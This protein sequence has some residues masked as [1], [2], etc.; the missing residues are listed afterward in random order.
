MQHPVRHHRST[1]E[2]TTEAASLIWKI[3]LSRSLG[4]IKLP[5]LVPSSVIHRRPRPLGKQYLTHQPVL[6]QPTNPN[7]EEEGDELVSIGDLEQDDLNELRAL[8][9]GGKGGKRVSGKGPQK[10][11]KGSGRG[12]HRVR[13]LRPLRPFAQSDSC[14]RL[15]ST[16]DQ[17]AFVESAVSPLETSKV[18]IFY[19]ARLLTRPPRPPPRSF[20]FKTNGE[21]QRHPQRTFGTL[22][23]LPN[24][25][26][27]HLEHVHHTPAPPFQM[28][29]DS[30]RLPSSMTA[31]AVRSPLKRTPHPAKHSQTPRPNLPHDHR[32]FPLPSFTFKASRILERTP[33]P[34]APIREPHYPFSRP[35]SRKNATTARSRFGQ[36]QTRPT[37]DL[38]LPRAPLP[39]PPRRIIT[40]FRTSHDRL[41]PLRQGRT[42]PDLRPPPSASLTT[43]SVSPLPE[44]MGEIHWVG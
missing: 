26:F 34:P 40:N 7:E 33:P 37:S 27:I 39:P 10:S 13:E 28:I 41:L 43:V 23:P 5:H 2:T 25:P 17:A 1:E 18:M 3:S 38:P 30:N 11:W 24:L 21:P 15:L 8:D 32:R 16:S 14:S 22:W 35:T 36:D 19:P 42:W 44:L 12:E 9:E 20:T 6:Q 29:Q 31:I 4:H